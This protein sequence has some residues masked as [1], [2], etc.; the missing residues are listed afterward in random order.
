MHQALAEARREAP[1]FHDPTLNAWVVTR[2]ADVV[3]VFRDPERFSAR[4]AL[5]PV[6]TS[7]EIVGSVL[8]AGHYVGVSTNADLDP[9]DHGRIRRRVMP[10][11]GTR[12][13][14]QLE[15]EVRRIIDDSLDRLP[16]S[17]R[18]ELVSSLTY[19]MPV[20]VLFALLGLPDEDVARVKQW[21]QHFIAFVFGRPTPEQQVDAANG[22]IAWRNYGA[23]LVARRQAAPGDDLVSDLIR[24]HQEDPDSLSIV[25]IQGYIQGLLVAGHETTTHQATN[26][27]R[28]L[29]E[30]PS[31][32]T[33][34]ADD[35]SKVR[36]TV[37]ECIRMEGSVVAWRRRALVDVEVGGVTIPAGSTVLLSLASGNRDE[38]Q[39]PEPD[40]FVI[41]RV[42]ARPHLSFGHG[43]H[44]CI[45]A[46]LARLELNY[47]LEAMTRRFPRMRLAEQALAYTETVSFRGPKALWVEMDPGPN[48]P[49]PARG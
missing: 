25:E 40:A 45:G 20:R 49:R 1:V 44:F 39:F 47:L 33:A 21:A 13:L 12:R 28:L 46:P 41:D 43:I 31:R 9:P 14:E 27:I 6:A 32:W 4:V 5:T 38:A 42:M 18:V 19:E 8:K 37:E 11:I 34:L 26:A 36:T 30:D 29:L 7:P 24:V 17:G 2:Y 35:P 48:E 16:T 23:D 10:L 3:A 15:P 22:L